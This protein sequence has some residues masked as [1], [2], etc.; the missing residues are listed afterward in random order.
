MNDF[1]FTKIAGNFLDDLTSEVDSKSGTQL[2][3]VEFINKELNLGV[4]LY[5]QQ[6]TILKMFYGHSLNDV[7]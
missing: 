3:I 2:N 1:D 7:E 4:E 5:P 6:I